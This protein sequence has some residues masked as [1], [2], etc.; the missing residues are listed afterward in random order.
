[1]SYTITSCVDV[2]LITK[3]QTTQD[4]Y[5]SPSADVMG[6]TLTNL[7]KLIRLPFGCG[8]QNMIHFAPNIYVMSYLERTGQLTPDIKSEATGFLVQGKT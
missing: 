7:Q 6:P 2:V 4:F 1:M 5:F 8:E 3:V